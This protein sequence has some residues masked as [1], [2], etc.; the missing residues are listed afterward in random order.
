M[1][2]AAVDGEMNRPQAQGNRNN[3]QDGAHHS[4]IKDGVA[5]RRAPIRSKSHHSNPHGATHLQAQVPR[6]VPLLVAVPVNQPPTQTAGPTR[7][8]PR[9]PHGVT[10]NPADTDS[11]VT[12]HVKA[13][14]PTARPTMW[15]AISLHVTAVNQRR[16]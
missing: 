1:R 7:N 10:S 12:T 8:P 4:K 15:S 3:S 9:N 11:I 13:A 6:L 2:G 14:M 5:H 16:N